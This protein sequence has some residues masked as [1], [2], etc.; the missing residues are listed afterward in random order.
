MIKTLKNALLA[1]LLTSAA[2]AAPALAATTSIEGFWE[3]ADNHAMNAPQKPTFTPA[4]NELVALARKIGDSKDGVIVSSRY[5]M[6]LGQ[7]WNLVQSAPI[8]VVQ[9]KRE[10]TMMYEGHSA[11]WHIYTDG[12][13][14]PDPAQWKL[15][16]NG[17][18]IGKW[19]GDT[20]VVDTVGFLT[21]PEPS[22]PGGAILS[23]TTHLVAR[24][25]AA[26]DGQSLH[27]HFTAEDPVNLTKPYSWDYTWKRSAPGNYAADEVCDP[28]ELKNARY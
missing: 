22:L 19:E 24:F 1:A 15:H 14:H 27:G 23:P 28:R 6:D 5:C 3:P 12:R 13:G 20:F 16:I 10:T 17:H 7:P 21:K 11:P 4:G 18:S 26:A 9:D 25:T 8:D 2:L